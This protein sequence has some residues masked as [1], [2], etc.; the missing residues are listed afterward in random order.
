MN[1]INFMLQ[2]MLIT[3]GEYYRQDGKRS[4]DQIRVR[5]KGC[6]IQSQETTISNQKGVE[7]L[8]I[9]YK[10]LLVSLAGMLRSRSR[11]RKTKRA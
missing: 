9:T 1:T 3:S 4:A 11:I 10:I 7:L 6:Q 8:Y 5:T 2:P